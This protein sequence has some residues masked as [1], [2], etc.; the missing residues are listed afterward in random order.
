MIKCTGQIL[1]A[2]SIFCAGDIICNN[3]VICNGQVSCVG[4][5]ICNGHIDFAGDIFCD[6][7]Q[8]GCDGNIDC[9]HD[10]IC[11]VGQNLFRTSNLIGSCWPEALLFQSWGSLLVFFLV[12]ATYCFLNQS[13][14]P[15]LEL[16]AH[17]I[18]DGDINC[19]GYTACDKAFVWDGYINHWNSPLVI[20]ARDLE[21]PI[22]GWKN[23]CI[24]TM[25]SQDDLIDMEG[26]FKFTICNYLGLLLQDRDAEP[27]LQTNRHTQSTDP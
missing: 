2:G 16:P 15:L 10:V 8:F 22:R 23:L 19:D 5:I 18:C 24:I 3:E 25:G 21:Q 13:C 27:S 7:Q 20:P 12:R 6:Y 9:S 4:Q 11:A 26:D 1:C 17:P 14:E